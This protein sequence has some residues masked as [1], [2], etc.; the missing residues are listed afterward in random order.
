MAVGIEESLVH[1]LKSQISLTT[2]VGARIFPLLVPSDEPRV[3]IVYHVISHE[4]ITTF[5]NVGEL[6][7]P[8]IDLKVWG[9]SYAEVK[10]VERVLVPLLDGFQG[11]WGPIDT[12][13]K[14][15]NCEIGDRHDIYE[16]PVH[17]DETGNYGVLLV[18]H[19]WYEER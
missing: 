12:K 13:V 6:A 18:L 2:L 11:E 9:T 3:A 14:I 17:S 10:A 4:R 19:I 15:Q 1:Y 5:T 8:V 16:R 7:M